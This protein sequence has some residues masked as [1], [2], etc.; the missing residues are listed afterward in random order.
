MDK[1]LKEYDKLEGTYQITRIKRLEKLAYIPQVIGIILVFA[2]FTYLGGAQLKPFYLPIFISFLVTIIWILV[3][4]IEFFVFRLMEIGFRKSASAKFLMASRSMKKSYSAIVVFGVIFLLLF[5]PYMPQQIEEQLSITGEITITEEEAIY[6]TSRDRFDFT[7][8]DSISVEVL[9]GEGRVDVSILT[10]SN[11][12]DRL[13]GMKVNRNPGDPNEASYNDVFE[14]DMPALRFDEYR[15]VLQPEEP[16]TVRYTIDSNLPPSRTY[17]FA[18]LSLGFLISYS[19]FA[20]LMFPIKKKH[21][22]EAIYR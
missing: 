6:F 9:D 13:F 21:S 4:A 1:R 17:P 11:Y 22:D 14:Y 15:L 5:T 3:I 16:V 7:I 2:F 18:L 12:E 10:E 19:V 8:V 20:F